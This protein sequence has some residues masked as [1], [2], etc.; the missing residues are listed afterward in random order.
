MP[1]FAPGQIKTAVAPIRV[2]PAGLACSAEL[3]LGA[4]VATSGVKS[5]NSTGVRQDISFP[6]TMPDVEG[7]YPVYLDI[8]AQGMLIGAYKA[9]EDVVIKAPVISLRVTRAYLREDSPKVSEAYSGWI[10]L[11]L[12]SQLNLG[13]FGRYIQAGALIV[14]RSSIPVVLDFEAWNH[15][16]IPEEERTNGSYTDVP[17]VLP[18][19]EPQRFPPAPTGLAYS[20][21]Q[22]EA[23]KFCPPGTTLAPG[24]TGFVYTA[25]YSQGRRWNYINLKIYANGQEMDTVRLYYGWYSY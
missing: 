2:Q 12:G 19:F 23:D 22:Y 17:L 13:L 7:T 10:S 9:I 16:W 18:Q 21:Y 6:L 25:L 3:Y 5:F 24:E 1:E 14:N 8:A 11:T 4:K 20:S 15:H